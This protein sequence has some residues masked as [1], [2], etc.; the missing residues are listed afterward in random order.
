[1]ER[2]DWL[3]NIRID[4]ARLTELFGLHSMERDENAVFCGPVGVG[5]CFLAQAVGYAACRADNTCSL[6]EP[7]GSYKAWL[8]LVRTTPSIGNSTVSSL[9]ISWS[10]MILP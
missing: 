10:S 9:R 7:T 1:V 6:F 3:A 8:D 2:F 5:K 4:N